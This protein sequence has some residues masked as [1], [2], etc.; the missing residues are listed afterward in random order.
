M[1]EALDVCGSR[2]AQAGPHG[3]KQAGSRPCMPG[4]G[5]AA[6]AVHA[7]HAD[8]TSHGL[9]FAVVGLY[10]I[11]LHLVICW[12]GW[13]VRT[14][15]RAT[16][17]GAEQRETERAGTEGRQPTPVVGESSHRRV[18][19]TGFTT[20]ELR[21]KLHHDGLRSLGSKTELVDRLIAS[22]RTCTEAQAGHL[23]GLQRQGR[24]IDLSQATAVHNTSRWIDGTT[25]SRV[26]QPMEAGWRRP[27]MNAFEASLCSRSSAGECERLSPA[28]SKSYRDT[29]AWATESL[30]ARGGS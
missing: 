23:L 1:S 14:T 29:T 3:C 8:G 26:A 9:S 12:L 2:L 30:H 21:Q 16:G 11:V 17:E 25:G 19:L 6:M 27:H 5:P 7:D 28:W 24:G 13:R 10:I 18:L 4:R 22:G 15:G 20:E